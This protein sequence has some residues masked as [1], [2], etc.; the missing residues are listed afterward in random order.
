VSGRKFS[1]PVALAPGVNE[2]TVAVRDK[3]GNE[4]RPVAGRVT[5]GGAALGEGHDYKPEVLAAVRRLL[6]KGAFRPAESPRNGEGMLVLLHVRTSQPFVVVPGGTFPMGSTE[7]QF[8][9]PV[10]KVAVGPFLLAATECTRTDFVRLGGKARPDWEGSTLPAAPV[11]FEEAQ[12][13]CASHGLRLPSEA[14]WEYACRAGSI[15]RFPFG[16]DEGRLAEHGW[17][18][19]S[20]GR[21]PLPP[22]TPFDPRRA[23]TEYGCAPHGA[24]LLAPNR[25]GFFDLL[26]NAAEWVADDWRPDY[27]DA[28]ADGRPRVVEGKAPRVLRGG[29]CVSPAK[30]CRS[31]ARSAAEATGR[32]QM[33]GFRPAANLP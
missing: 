11:A 13:W 22:D 8:E 27:T 18:F 23:L 16:N 19:L 5:R 26:G 7:G 25:W 28:P 2:I 4:G 24:A 21:R 3:A 30:D 17:F 31:S 6:S 9:Q 15:A 20:S 12:R 33:A 10:R 14:E 1:A 32:G 29:S